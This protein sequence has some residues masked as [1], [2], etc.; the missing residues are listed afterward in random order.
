ML[1]A[2]AAKAGAVA[3]DGDAENSP[4][5]T[6]LLNHLTEPGLDLPSRSAAFEMMS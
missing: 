2:F 3:S 6:A 5:A 4:F 1:I